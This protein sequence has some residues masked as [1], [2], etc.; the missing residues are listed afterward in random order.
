MRAVCEQPGRA[1]AIPSPS[2]IKSALER[3]EA[4]VDASR[5]TQI[6]RGRL[7]REQVWRQPRALVAAELETRLE[8]PQNVAP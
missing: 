5:A 6:G 3:R 2:K 4:I 1:N 7:L 8:L